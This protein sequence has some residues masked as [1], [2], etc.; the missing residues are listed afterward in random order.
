MYIKTFQ[1]GFNHSIDKYNNFDFC[2]ANIKNH[3]HQNIIFIIE[4]WRFKIIYRYY[5]QWDTEVE[6]STL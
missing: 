3:I 2:K 1:I 4:I 6:P 5:V